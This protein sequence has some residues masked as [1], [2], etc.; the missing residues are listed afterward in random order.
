MKKTKLIALFLVVIMLA[1][2]FVGC[3]P[4]AT[5]EAPVDTPA[6]TE[7]AVETPAAPLKA[8]LLMSGV[9]NDGGWNQSAYEGLV[10]LQDELGYEIAFTEKVQQADQ[11]NIMR[12]YAKK[13]FN[14]IVGHGFEYGDALVAVAAEYPEVKFAQVGGGSGGMEPNITSGFT[15]GSDSVLVFCYNV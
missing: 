3:A 12:D 15:I 11:A 8:A 4:K 5:E 1:S 6:T 9:I 13:G 2:M 10:K 14:L 7:E